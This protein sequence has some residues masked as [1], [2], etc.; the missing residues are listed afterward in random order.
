M[1]FMQHENLSLYSQQPDSSHPV[2][3]DESSPEYYILF[4]ETNF[5]TLPCTSITSKY[6]FAFRLAQDHP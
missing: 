3:R 4:L 6:P 1:P 2:E 5:N